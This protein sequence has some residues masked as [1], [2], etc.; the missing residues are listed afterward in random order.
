MNEKALSCANF[1][2]SRRERK[3]VDGCMMRY[4]IPWFFEGSGTSSGSTSCVVR[5][6]VLLLLNTS[7][8]LSSSSAPVLAQRHVQLL[9]HFSFQE[10]DRISAAEEL[11]VL[12]GFHSHHAIYV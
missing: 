1:V 10:V 4:L 6:Q 12:P 3:I 8:V 5:M 11:H 9:D 7:F 2:D